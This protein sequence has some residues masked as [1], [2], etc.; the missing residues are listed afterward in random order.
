[1][2]TPAQRENPEQFKQKIILFVNLPARFECEA[3]RAGNK[4][5][6]RRVNNTKNFSLFAQNTAG[7]G[8]YYLGWLTSCS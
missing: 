7:I 6:I 5:V 3:F 8:S 4:F 2:Q 1:M